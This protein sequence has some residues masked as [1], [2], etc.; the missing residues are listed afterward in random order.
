MDVTRVRRGPRVGVWNLRKS[1]DSSQTCGRVP[2]AVR[3]SICCVPVM[4]RAL[5]IAIAE[6]T[7]PERSKKSIA[8]KSRWYKTNVERAGA[9]SPMLDGSNSSLQARSPCTTAAALCFP[10]AMPT[11]LMPSVPILAHASMHS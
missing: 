7:Q 9:L 2:M 11:H 6:G 8:L 1:V 4:V 10:A 3:P 5:G